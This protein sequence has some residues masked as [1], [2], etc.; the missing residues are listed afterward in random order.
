MMDGELNTSAKCAPEV[1]VAGGRFSAVARIA[2][3]G[4]MRR[5]AMLPTRHGG[6]PRSRSSFFVIT[7]FAGTLFYRKAGIRISPAWGSRR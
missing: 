1:G 3:E 6:H 4:E 2:H 5:M 7:F